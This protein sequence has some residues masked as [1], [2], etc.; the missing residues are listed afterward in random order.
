M[1]HNTSIP[2]AIPKQPAPRL[3]SPLPDY[4]E[5]AAR[6]PS[7]SPTAHPKPAE[8]H[9]FANLPKEIQLIIISFA[10]N[11]GRVL[12][13]H[14]R[15]IKRG[16]RWKSRLRLPP[17]SQPPLLLVNRE[18]RH[19]SLKHYVPS[20]QLA[21]ARSPSS[22]KPTIPIPIS[23][24]LF[25]IN[26]LADTISIRC[27]PR[28]PL[29]VQRDPH[30]HG[31]IQT[32]YEAL[33]RAR[34][35]QCLALKS[36]RLSHSAAE[37]LAYTSGVPHLDDEDSLESV[38]H[39]DMEAQVLR[40]MFSNLEVLSFHAEDAGDGTSILRPA[41]TTAR[42]AWHVRRRC[43]RRARKRLI[44]IVRADEAQDEKRAREYRSSSEGQAERLALLEKN[45]EITEEGIERVLLRSSR[46]YWLRRWNLP[47]FR[48]V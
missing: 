37:A 46:I 47:R 14:L 20:S 43:I 29:L 6:S 16:N 4:P 13:L 8:F 1:A 41:G 40:I 42:A 44:G 11:Q 35:L 22:S 17:T 30:L 39:A 36:L 32:L 24:S 21:L 34:G 7:P 45:P 15:Y 28:Y 26:F 33:Y 12:T 31:A 2:A 10:A 9:L 48:A 19:E 23:T 25:P 38:S 18:F 5:A 3:P 27:P